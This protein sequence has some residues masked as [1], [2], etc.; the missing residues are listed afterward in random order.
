M[1][2]PPDDPSSF[3]RVP[4]REVYDSLRRIE[5][6]VTHVDSAVR[7]NTRDYADLVKRVR[8]LELRFYGI[9]AGLVT[10]LGVILYQGAAK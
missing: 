9:L 2:G 1:M 3:I 5:D 4:L 10:A 6:K 7:D 8:A